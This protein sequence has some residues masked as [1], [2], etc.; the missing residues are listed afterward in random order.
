MFDVVPVVWHPA[1]HCVSQ[2]NG[3]SACLQVY[4]EHDIDS[5]ESDMAVVEFVY[6]DKT[7]QGELLENMPSSVL[8]GLL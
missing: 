8:T 3:A 2:S 5:S 6:A 1:A 7:L 4:V